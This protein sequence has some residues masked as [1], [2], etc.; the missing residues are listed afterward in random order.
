MDRFF[1]RKRLAWRTW[2]DMPVGLDA[3]QAVG[4]GMARTILLG[5]SGLRYPGPYDGSIQQGW[6]VLLAI[7]NTGRAAVHGH[8]FSAP[9]TVTFPGRQIH[10]ARIGHDLARQRRR[11]ADSLPGIRISTGHDLEPGAKTRHVRMHLVGDYVL[12]P[13]DSYT[14]MLVLSGTPTAPTRHVRLDGTLTGGQL[15]SETGQVAG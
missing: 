10:T 2:I 15:I 6:L 7:I 13:N 4:H 11:P 12:H 5:E 14:V 8:D 9:L 1:I 3:G